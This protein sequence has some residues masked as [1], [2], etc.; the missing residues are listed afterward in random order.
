MH[1]RMFSTLY[2]PDSN[3]IYIY[4]YIYIY[5]FFF[6]SSQDDSND[7]GESRPLGA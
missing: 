4:I 2:P 6:L 5:I 3:E 1:C 7:A